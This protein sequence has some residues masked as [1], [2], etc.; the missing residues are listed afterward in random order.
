MAKAKIYG[1]LTPVPKAKDD[2]RYRRKLCQRD[3]ESAKWVPG[4]IKYNRLP[5]LKKG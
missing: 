1:M 5:D 2:M 4:Q 3:R